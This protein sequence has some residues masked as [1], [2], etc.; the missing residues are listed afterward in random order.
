MRGLLLAA[1]VGV[2]LA[3]PAHRHNTNTLTRRIVDLD[4]FRLVTNTTYSNATVTTSE[5]A[6]R[7]L[8]RATYVDTATALVQSVV[9]GAEF[10]VSDEY[11]GAN[12]I[13]VGCFSL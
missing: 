8:R 6:T 12:G 1:F 4:Q 10:R 2:S 13:A 3:H 7:L 5:P 11:V 9:P